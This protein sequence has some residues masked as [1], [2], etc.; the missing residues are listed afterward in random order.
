MRS[1]TSVAALDGRKGPSLGNGRLT[2]PR[3]R[4]S[5]PA[6]SRLSRCSPLPTLRI[7]LSH[8]LK[9]H[10]EPAGSPQP[11]EPVHRGRGSA[12]I[13]S[14]CLPGCSGESALLGPFLSQPQSSRSPWPRPRPRPRPRPQPR[15]RPRPSEPLRRQGAPS[16]LSCCIGPPYRVPD[17]A[18]GHQSQTHPST[19]APPRLPAPCPSYVPALLAG[20]ESV[21][22]ICRPRPLARAA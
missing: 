22:L 6:A 4:P 7:R 10:P 14:S 1:R 18:L 21:D 12:G 19:H 20:R 16:H 3:R 8:F 13:D 15:P 2:V 9:R 5:P 17:A 11:P